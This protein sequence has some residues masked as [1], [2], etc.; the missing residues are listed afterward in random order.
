MKTLLWD[1][2][3]TNQVNEG[4]CIKT[5]PLQSAASHLL[6]GERTPTMCNGYSKN[7]LRKRSN[8][9]K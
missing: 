1:K 6:K 8:V 5:S 4:F 9:L 3:F 2:Q 7:D